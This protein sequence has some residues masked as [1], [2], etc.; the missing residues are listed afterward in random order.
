MRMTQKLWHYEKDNQAYGPVTEA[1]ILNLIVEGSIKENTLVW[2]H[3]MT[4]W[5]P[6]SS[7]DELRIG[8]PPKPPPLPE[9]KTPPPLPGK[10][11]SPF[12]PPHKLAP[13]PFQP[14]LPTTAPS[15]AYSGTPPGAASEQPVPQIRPWARFGARMFDYLIFTTILGLLFI[16]SGTDDEGRFSGYSTFI[17]LFLWIFVEAF[18]LS[19]HGTTPG[20]HLLNTKVLNEDGTRLS[21]SSALNRSANVWLKGIALGIPFVSLISMLFAYAQLNKDGKTSWDKNGGCRVVHGDIDSFNLAMVTII[22]SVL[23]AGSIIAFVLGIIS[24]F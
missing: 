22:I 9:R 18:F 16:L 3:P 17:F 10:E 5:A 11:K 23:I 8:F 13:D 7:I 6:A 12:E 20:K 14:P 15:A 1:E 4:E 21:Y 24:H 19:L 2:S